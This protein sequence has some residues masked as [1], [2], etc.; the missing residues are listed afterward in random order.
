MNSYPTLFFKYSHL[1]D[2]ICSANDPITEEWAREA[3]EKELEFSNIWTAE[4][5]QL[6]QQL[7][8]DFNKGF[9]RK[10]L[11]ATLSVCAKA[12]SFS[13]P[14]VLNVTRFLKSYMK[15]KPVRPNYVFVDLVFHELL[16]TWLV[17]NLK[18]PTPL[19]VKYKNEPRSLV[20]HLHLIALQIHIYTKL[21]RSDLLQWIED[22]YPNMQGVY[23]HAWEIV[24]KTEGHQ[25]FIDEVK[26]GI[27]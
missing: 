15:D 19:S 1:Y 22:Y 7:F 5:P 11:T 14:L 4:A 2:G 6:F 27:R 16:H 18:Q 26:T 25:A 20:A 10:E 24:T 3:Q 12:P 8:L 23:P 9:L 21:K 17:E 13:D